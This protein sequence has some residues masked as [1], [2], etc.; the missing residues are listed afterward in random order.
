[1]EK[2]H[3]WPEGHWSWPIGVT[4]KHGVRCAEMVWVG[5]QVDLTPDGVVCNP[6]DL[7]A[8]T[9]RA[10]AHFARVLEEL[11]CDFEDLVTLL[12][13]YVN[14]GGVDEAGFLAAVGECLPA[15]AHPAVTA[16]P[17]PYLAY[18]G[19]QVEIEGYAMR[20]E[21][22]E[23]TPRTFADTNAASPPA[24]PVPSR[25]PQRQDDL[26]VRAISD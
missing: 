13:F 22:G 24:R 19:L 8:Q 20:R 15:G 14:D 10:M 5:G 11:D 26:R 7:A 9:R 18:E 1:M 6:G 16:V 17:V 4:H 21:S 23:R 12:C 2:R 25:G 3:A